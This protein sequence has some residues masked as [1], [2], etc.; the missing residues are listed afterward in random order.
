[1]RKLNL[2]LFHKNLKRHIL[3]PRFLAKKYSTSI[4]IYQDTGF[5]MLEVLVVVVIIG[6]LSAILAPSWLAFVNRQQVNKANDTILA[7]LQDAQRQAKN[8][9]LSYSVSLQTK[10]GI[11]QIA[12]YQ[13]VDK[14]GNK[15]TPSN[16]RDLG[17]E[18]GIKSGQLLIGTNLKDGQVNTVISS[19]AYNS[20]TPVTITFDYMGN[21][22][23]ADLGK[24]STVSKEIPG[25]RIL[26]AAPKAGNPT[27]P[28]E[29][30]RC[31]IVSTLIG[32]MRT[33]KD[34]K[35]DLPK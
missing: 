30:K 23:N 10:S 27:Q 22:P 31:V 29:T 15:V 3:Q 9:K 21:L 8:K 32:G 35:C 26:A 13:S 18:L 6:I 24:E 19:I 12:L 16:W 4:Y 33:D 5:T 14:D 7:A 28:S 17:A 25:L 34:S 20:T 2:K 11:P 1:M